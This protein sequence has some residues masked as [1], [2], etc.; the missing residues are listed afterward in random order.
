VGSYYF[1]SSGLVK[2]YI[3]E[4]GTTWVRTI[5]D[6]AAG[7]DVIV[8]CLTG[9]EVVSA[10]ISHSP[11]LQPSLLNQALTDFRHDFRVQYQ[12]RGVTDPLIAEA[13]RLAEVHHLRGYDAVQ[14]AAAKEVDG[15]YK[16]TG[17]LLT[18]VSADRRLN[19]AATAEG[20]T[21]DNPQSH[22]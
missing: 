1:D 11:P 9:V 3:A 10:L 19:I 7:N 4:T 17:L 8:V 2:R 6:P 5:T 18:F 13:M 20:L 15:Q 16:G 14:L 22:P 12:V 21:V